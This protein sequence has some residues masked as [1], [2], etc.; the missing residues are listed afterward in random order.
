MATREMEWACDYYN[1]EG[2]LPCGQVRPVATLVVNPS[3]LRANPASFRAGVRVRPAGIIAHRLGGGFTKRGALFRA[4][5]SCAQHAGSLVMREHLPMTKAR[6][7]D[8]QKTLDMITDIVERQL[9]KL[10]PE[11]A[12]AKRKEIHRI[13]SSAGS[14]GRGKSLKPSRTR[15]NRLSTRS[16][17]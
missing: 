10:P 4:V 3:K 14:R 5:L 12:D 7:S 16:P 8:F 11:I 1:V 9:S 15:G 13:A 2:R 6:K 17:A